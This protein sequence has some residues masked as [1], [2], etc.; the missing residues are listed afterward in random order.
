MVE[1][2][3]RFADLHERHPAV[4]EV[5]ANYFAEAVAV[6]LDRHHESPQS[7]CIAESRGETR[8]TARWPAPDERMIGAW[9][10]S[11]DIAATEAGAYALALAAV[12]LTRGMVALTPGETGSGCDY[13]VGAPGTPLTSVSRLIRLEI[14]GVDGGEP[15]RLMTRLKQKIRQLAR[16]RSKLSGVAVTVGFKTLRILLAE[17]KEP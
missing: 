1:E 9:R 8:A 13:Y 12:E 17:K 15:S 5:V 14:S 4:G 3:L 7:F 6:C 11:R 16:G 2:E 10:N